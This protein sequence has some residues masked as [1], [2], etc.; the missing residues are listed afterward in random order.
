MSLWLAPLVGVSG[1][2]VYR[3]WRHEAAVHSGELMDVRDVM[4]EGEADLELRALGGRFYRV[5]LQFEACVRAPASEDERIE[6]ADGAARLPYRLGVTRSDGALLYER[7]RPLSDLF[8]IASSEIER[9]GRGR[10]V[11]VQSRHWG[12]VPLL[13]FRSSTLGRLRFE[14]SIATP[15]SGVRLEKAQLVL[16]EG[17]KRLRHRKALLDRIEIEAEAPRPAA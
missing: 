6:Q 14:F 13:D 15:Q 1:L 9:V 3:A 2:L 16:K 11:E 12:C 17:V 10:S 8:G 5:E 7:E 4:P